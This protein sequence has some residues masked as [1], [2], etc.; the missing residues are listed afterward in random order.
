M[1]LTSEFTIAFCSSGCSLIS[2]STFILISRQIESWLIMN[3]RNS[4]RKPSLSCRVCLSFEVSQISSSTSYSTCRSAF[5]CAELIYVT[6]VRSSRIQSR[7]N[8]DRSLNLMPFGLSDWV[9]GSTLCSILN[10]TL[11]SDSTKPIL[12]ALMLISFDFCFLIVSVGAP[13]TG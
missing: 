7:R 9:L 5:G 1:G 11:K 12:P 2:F 10:E 8:D 6:T 4:L 13:C 3:L